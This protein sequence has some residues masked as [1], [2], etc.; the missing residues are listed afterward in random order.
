MLRLFSF[1]AEY[2][3][4]GSSGKSRLT[5][6]SC[7]DSPNLAIPGILKI[8]KMQGF[9]LYNLSSTES[10]APLDIAAKQLVKVPYQYLC[11]GVPEKPEYPVQIQWYFHPQPSARC[12]KVAH[13]R[14][15][16]MST[17]NLRNHHATHLVP[18]CMQS[19]LRFRT[20][21]EFPPPDTVHIP[22]FPCNRPLFIFL[23]IYKPKHI[24]EFILLP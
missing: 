16:P 14:M 24:R 9:Y 19:I 5:F 2:P 13:S 11:A 21:A 4:R 6:V 12:P 1:P 15:L 8:Y 10:D 3:A 20:S 17:S 23:H 7:R 18:P 22:G